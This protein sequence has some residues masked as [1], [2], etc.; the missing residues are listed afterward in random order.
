M[1]LQPKS[2]RP[3]RVYSLNEGLYMRLFTPEEPIDQTAGE[4]GGLQELQ[5][6]KQERSMEPFPA[7][8]IS[9]LLSI[10][11]IQSYKP[12]SQLGPESQPYNIRMKVGD[13]GFRLRLVFD[14]T[15]L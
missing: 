3:W 10:P 9:F 5:P 13:D 11:P 7:G 8:D 6:R 14:F 15:S 1:E 12:L 4:M 2:G